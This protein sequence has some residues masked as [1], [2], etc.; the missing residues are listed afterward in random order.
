MRFALIS[1]IAAEENSEGGQFCKAWADLVRR[2]IDLVKQKDTEATFLFPRWGLTGFD[3][4]FHTYLHHLNDSE[5]F[6]VAFQAEKE[7]FDA[8]ILS[9]FYDP[10]LR[11]LRQAVNIPVVSMLESSL[12]LALMMG[13]KVGVV[14]VSPEAACDH[15]E[16]IHKYGLRERA[17]RIRPIPE[18][19]EEQPMALMDAHRDIEAFKKV[20][21]ELIADGADVLIPACGLMSPAL[22]LAPGAE[23][24]YPNGLTEVDGVPVMDSIGVA[25][26]MVEAL[27]SL[28]QAGSSWI[29]RKAFYAQATPKALE[30]GQMVLKYDG[31]GFWSY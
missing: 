26:K 15:E 31:P 10:M 19:A 22:R 20:A 23:K 21:R 12:A 8:V 28:K 16:L 14:T 2:N 6:H 25:I 9:C 5:T 7:G 13:A 1:V 24:E 17:V 11:E 18:T 4:F 3:A 29:S 30:F 27:V